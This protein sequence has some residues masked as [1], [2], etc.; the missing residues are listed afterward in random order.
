MAA[1]PHDEKIQLSC[2]RAV[3]SVILF[4]RPNGLKAG[5]L[6]GLNYT[7]DFYGNHMDK[8]EARGVFVF[9]SFF[10]FFLILPE[11]QN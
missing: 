3:S 7:F 6:G 1:W 9:F 2:A 8:P 5:Q 11:G 10:R 4:H